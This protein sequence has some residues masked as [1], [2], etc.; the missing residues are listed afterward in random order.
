MRN[1]PLDQK[2]RKSLITQCCKEQAKN[3][4]VDLPLQVWSVKSVSRRFT[5]MP[6]RA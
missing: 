2:T 3:K 4:V 6:K 5:V 1:E